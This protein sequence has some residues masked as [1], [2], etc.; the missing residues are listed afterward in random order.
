MHM[1]PQLSFEIPLLFLLEL[2]FGIGFNQLV[3]WVNRHNLWHV[4][5][6]V[7]LGVAGTLLI[8][9]IF[10]A[11]IELMFWQVALIYFLCFAASGLPMVFG[12]TRRTVKESHHRRP[13]PNNAMRVRDDV[14][15]DINVTI[16]KVVKNEVEIASLVHWM[17]KWIGALKSM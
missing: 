13:L 3:A 7:V 1:N 17:H 14:V 8:P 16:E 10:L 4:S 9:M 12:S 11:Q 6:S 2:L 5:I 15:M